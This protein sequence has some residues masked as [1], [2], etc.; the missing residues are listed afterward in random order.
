MEPAAPPQIAS[1]RPLLPSPRNILTWPTSLRPCASVSLTCLPLRHHLLRSL[2]HQSSLTF[3]VLTS[4]DYQG[5]PEE[6]RIMVASFY[7]DGP[8]LSWFQ[9]MFR[10]GVIT[11][12]PALLQ[13]IESRFAP[14][15][16]DD[17]HGALFKLIQQG[18]VTEYLTEFEKLAN[19]ITGLSPSVLL[20]YFISGLTL[21]RLQED[22]I[23]DHRKHIRSLFGH[24][25]PN[26]P[27]PS[28]PH[29]TQTARPKPPFLQRTQEDMAYRREIGLC[30]N[31][32]EKW[33]SSHRCKGRVLFFI[34]ESDES[35][36]S[37]MITVEPSNPSVTEPDPIIDDPSQLFDPTS[38]QP[39][40]TSDPPHPIPAIDELLLKYQSLFNQPS[41]LPPPRQHAQ[42]G[43]PVIPFI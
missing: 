8:A 14:S 28:N 9:W 40:I 7:L 15:I 21:A 25:P 27:T 10:N 17:P 6:D 41:S 12:W 19:H 29:T 35:P 18:T 26:N 38:L 3:R 36:P 33:S 30:Y 31:C 24:P 13:A 16:Y 22:K 32:D 4:F 23:N 20:N 43:A 42:Y 34:T 5:T 2:G 1:R 37:E 39:Y 11:S